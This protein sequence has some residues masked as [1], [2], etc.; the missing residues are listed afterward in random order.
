M[1]YDTC[2][3]DTDSF[4]SP[5]S[6]VYDHVQ[7]ERGASSFTLEE[8]GPALAIQGS[9]RPLVGIRGLDYFDFEDGG[10]D[11]FEELPRSMTVNGVLDEEA[12]LGFTIGGGEVD[13]DTDALPELFP[14]QGQSEDDFACMGG[15]YCVTFS[16]AEST[17]GDSFLMTLHE[18]SQL[19]D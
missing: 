6:G 9:S 15:A 18:L 5:D 3:D 7:W 12:E 2:V 16:V 1:T 14:M 4:G 10:Y 13:F 11:V 8:G 19:E 17:F